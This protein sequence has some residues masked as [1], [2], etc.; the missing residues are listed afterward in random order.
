M[1]GATSGYCATGQVVYGRNRTLSLAPASTEKL[2]LSFALLSRLGPVYRIETRVLHTV[3]AFLASGGH[4]L[5]FRGPSGPSEPGIVV[6]PL[7]WQDT[8][9]LVDALQSRL[10]VLVKRVIGP[11]VSVPR[12]TAR[13]LDPT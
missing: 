6:P 5:L 9:P 1:G 2:A 11:V 3:Q 10:T 4:M 13:K 7:E 12:G 8:H